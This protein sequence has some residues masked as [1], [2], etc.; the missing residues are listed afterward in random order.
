MSCNV[1]F[2]LDVSVPIGLGHLARCLA[3][4]CAL[5]RRGGKA[6]FVCS[7][8]AAG[9]RGGHSPANLVEALLGRRTSFRLIELPLGIDEGEDARC[10]VKAA[11]GARID[12]VLVDHYGLGPEWWQAVR[13]EFPLAAIDDLGRP[14]LGDYVDLVVNQ[15]LGAREH[16]Y[17][18]A[19]RVLCGCRFALLREDFFEYR[20]RRERCWVEGTV[21]RRERMTGTQRVLVSMGGSDPNEV[22]PRVLRALQAIQRDFVAE[23]TLGTSIDDREEIFRRATADSR[24][25]LNEEPRRMSEVMASSDLAVTGGG[26]TVYE[27]AYLGV[28]H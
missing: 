9:E 18:P 13:A 22:T 27:C 16:W 15:N 5:E 3:L 24:F 6:G 28:P 2:R 17:K 11:S 14:G 19:P 23:I 20:S 25:V 7:A 12:V 1:M 10:T 26:S 4:A 8:V 21:A